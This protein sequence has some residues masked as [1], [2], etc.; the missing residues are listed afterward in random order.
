MRSSSIVMGMDGVRGASPVAG[1]SSAGGGDEEDGED[2]AALSAA[3]A[4]PALGRHRASSPTSLPCITGR[5]SFEK[6]VEDVFP[7]TEIFTC[8]AIQWSER[9]PM[10]TA[11]PHR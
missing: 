8:P 9:A 1:L 6:K 5:F 4:V 10:T 11:S 3:T 7:P 2:D